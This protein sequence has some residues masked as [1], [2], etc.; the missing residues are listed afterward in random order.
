MTPM[1]PN[2][3]ELKKQPFGQYIPDEVLQYRSDEIERIIAWARENPLPLPA[4][5]EI[6]SNRGCFL[7]GLTRG[8]RDVS[9]LGIELKL[10]L[11]RIA[12]RKLEREGLTNGHV[13]HADAKLAL[14]VLFQPH[15]VD[16]IYVLFPDPWWKRKHARRRLLDDSFFE[17]AHVFLKPGGFFVLKTDVLDYF[18]AVEEYLKSSPCFEF[19]DISEVPGSDSWTLSTRERH[20]L[21]DNLPY[22]QLAVRNLATEASELP[23]TTLIDK[24]LVKHNY[25]Y[26]PDEHKNN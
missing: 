12:M 8:R 15:T 9:F 22:K 7:L 18:D 5:I 23:K 13:I 4:E 11:C 6:G 20:C 19:V 1:N 21:E 3:A 2:W 17:T 16:A 25:S 24:K 26:H 14:P 10:G